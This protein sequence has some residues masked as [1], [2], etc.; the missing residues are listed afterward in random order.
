[1]SNQPES[2]V[3]RLTRQV[4]Q[5]EE[6][7]SQ[8]Q[9]L[10]ALG[11]LLGTTAHEFNNILTTIINYAQ[12]GMRHKDVPTREKAFEKILGA[13]QRAAKITKTILGSARNRKKEFEPIALS[14]L[15]DDVL[16]LLEREMTK[17]KVVIEKNYAEVPE[18][19]GDA[20]QLQQ[21]LLNLLINARQAMP[22]GGKL[23]MKLRY[24]QKTETVDLMIRDYGCGIPQ[25]KL[26]LIFDSFYSTK[27]GPDSSGKGGCG[28]GLSLCK[29]VIEG[30]KG[31][32]RVESSLGKGT[33]FTLKFPVREEPQTI[34]FPKTLAFPGNVYPDAA[35]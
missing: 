31:K 10:T 15:C 3:I 23:Q 5:L 32:I 13:S 16:L 14:E 28:L 29:Q 25:E 19:L 27:S 33:A 7:L 18:I 1:M 35:L 11:E 22:D 34:A 4:Q 2:E 24:D 12:L 20:N 21:V 26:P 6:R 30:H 8:A 9:R 17:Y